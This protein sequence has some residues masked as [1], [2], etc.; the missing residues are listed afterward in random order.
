MLRMTEVSRGEERR[1]RAWIR[2][3]NIAEPFENIIS[4]DDNHIEATRPVYYDLPA[5]IAIDS[6]GEQRGGSKCGATA[7]H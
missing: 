2:E 4:L 1:F 6:R 5:E 3:K 7:T